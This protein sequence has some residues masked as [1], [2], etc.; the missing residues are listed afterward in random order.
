VSQILPP[1]TLAPPSIPDA[2]GSFPPSPSP[3]PWWLGDGPGGTG[4]VA[5]WGAGTGDDVR[6]GLVDDG[7][8]IGH[9]ALTGADIEVLDGTSSQGN[10]AGTGGASLGPGGG[11]GTQVA[12]LIVGQSDDGQPGTGPGA[13]RGA[14][15]V[16]SPMALS[17]ALDPATVAARIVAQAQTVA[18]SNNSWGTTRA[19]EDNTRLTAWSDVAAAMDQAAQDGRGG[20]GTVMV[21]AGGNGR[22]TIAGQNRGDDANFH[23]LTNSRQ[24]IAVAASGEAGGVAFFS[25]PG[26][27]LLV[28]APGMG[29]TISAATPADPLATVSVSGTS[30]AAPLV[31]GTVGLM[32]ATNPALGWRDVQTILAM[33]ARPDPAVQGQG[34]GGTGWNGGGLIHSRDLGFGR[35]DAEAA[36]LLA[37]SWTTQSTSANEAQISVTHAPVISANPA[38]A[39]LTFEVSAEGAPM[40]VEWVTLT[41]TMTDARL[42]GLGIQLISPDGTVSVIAPNLAQAGGRTWLDFT[43][44]SA[45]TR[46][47]DAAGIW[48]V[49]LTHDTPTTR[50]SVYGARLDL[51]GAVDGADD[52][53]VFTRTFAPLADADPDRRVIRDLDGGDDTL[54]F[55]AGGAVDLDLRSSTGTVDGVAVTLEGTFERVIGSAGAD[56]VQAG[57]GGA[58]LTGNAGDD[59]LTGGTGA[60]R[61]DGGTGADLM[62]GGQGDDLYRIDTAGDRIIEEVGKGHDRLQSSVS[63]DLRLFGHHVEDATL[64]GTAAGDLTG[65]RAENML[66]GNDATNRIRGGLGDDRIDGGGGRD[67][68]DGG[69]GADTFVLSGVGDPDVIRDFTPGL[70][71]IELAN[72][73]WAGATWGLPGAA[74]GPM[75][76]QSGRTLWIDADGAGGADPVALATLR[77]GVVI[78]PDDLLF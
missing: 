46:G 13:A 52:V 69:M 67:V 57:D 11:H 35:L 23:S 38:M 73:D 1:F 48:T 26:A 44:S 53:Q 31:S 37:Q 71:R 42:S 54:N 72:P 66:I 9:V 74:E 58:V 32:L 20:L 45:V 5:A 41:L 25:S 51:F 19:F 2:G 65:N 63:V 78:G 60:D 70:D 27:N 17:G 55:A 29:L 36:V 12:A 3:L 39:D 33:T 34:N 62:A 49:R 16:V 4:L 22:L 43:F 10:A 8:D 28:A 24:S 75:V 76:W 30:F 50:M 77:A 6:I 64:T 14:T 61:L 18:V 15:L 40:T 68:L 7:I 47:E 59:S 56:R 21:F